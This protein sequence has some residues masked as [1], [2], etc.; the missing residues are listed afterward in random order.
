MNDVTVPKH[1]AELIR[2]LAK[3]I[4][5]YRPESPEIGRTA[6][7]KDRQREL[8]LIQDAVNRLDRMTEKIK[9]TIDEAVRIYEKIDSTSRCS[10]SHME[11]I[12]GALAG[13]PNPEF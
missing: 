8:E 4:D 5:C 12:E 9:S 6:M 7:I 3:Q 13:Q 10:E 2:E 1:I 11:D